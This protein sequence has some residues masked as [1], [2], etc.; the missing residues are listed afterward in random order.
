MQLFSK[1]VTAQKCATLM[2]NLFLIGTEYALT[3][4]LSLLFSS[5]L[6]RF[7]KTLTCTGCVSGEHLWTKL[8]KSCADALRT[9]LQPSWATSADL[10]LL[11]ALSSR[12]YRFFTSRLIVLPRILQKY[13][14][15]PVWWSNCVAHDYSRQHCACRKHYAMHLGIWK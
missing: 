13:L 6:T 12:D 4:L 15:L 7:L 5:E 1:L 11:I 14:W 8:S 10:H 2:S 3:L 9:R